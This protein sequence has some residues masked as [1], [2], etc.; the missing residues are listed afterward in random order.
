MTLVDSRPGIHAAL[1][2]FRAETGVAVN[3]DVIVT[4]LGPPI[5]TE[6][7][8]L[9]GAEALPAM[10]ATFR[11]HMAEVGVRAVTALPGAAGALGAVAAAGLRSLVVTAK[12]LPLARATLHHAGLAPDLV[13]GDV[14]GPDKAGP[15]REQGAI[16]YVGDHT[17]DIEAARTAGVVSVAVATGPIPAAGLAAA[18]VV[19][20]DLLGFPGWLAGVG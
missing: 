5:Q 20:A 10:L 12:H 16:A 4:R 14:W 8:P 6:L 19:L 9:V 1:V 15:L 17:G 2:A 3:A 13:A 11:R 18:D 7:L